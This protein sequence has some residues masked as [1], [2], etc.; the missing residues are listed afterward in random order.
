MQ[1]KKLFFLQRRS[2]DFLAPHLPYYKHTFPVVF[3]IQSA[4]GSREKSGAS[5]ALSRNCQNVRFLFSIPGKGNNVQPD[6]P[7]P[8]ALRRAFACKGTSNNH[9]TLLLC[10][11]TDWP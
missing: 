6:R 10:F 9:Y 8:T 5:P 7:L 2:L 1:K 4:C 3:I 11:F